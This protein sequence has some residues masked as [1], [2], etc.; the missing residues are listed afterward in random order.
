MPEKLKSTLD[1]LGKELDNHTKLTSD[2]RDALIELSAKIREELDTT[3]DTSAGD[4]VAATELE[5][6]VTHFRESHPDLSKMIRRVVDGLSGM[7]I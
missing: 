6:W 4:E 3:S 2:E 7:G 1:A 5:K